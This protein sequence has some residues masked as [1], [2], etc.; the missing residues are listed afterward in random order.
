M[1]IGVSGY[2]GYNLSSGIAWSKGSSI[3]SFLR[4]FHSVICLWALCM[5]SLEKCLFRS[6]AH[7]NWVV[8]L[9]GEESCNFFI[10]FGDQTLVRGII[11]KYIFP[12]GWFPFHFADVLFSRAEAFY[13]DEDRKLF[14]KIRNKRQEQN[15][16]G[17]KIASSTNG[18]GRSGQLHAKN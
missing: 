1:N 4:K 7:F 6:I 12:Y 10:S 11:C 18:V 9:L 5:S 3:F 16:N 13:F 17:V 2:L 8:C 15:C 14:A